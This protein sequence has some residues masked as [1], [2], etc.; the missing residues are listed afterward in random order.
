MEPNFVFFAY[1][2]FRLIQNL[3]K[4]IFSHAALDP[5]ALAA[6]A[7]IE[8]HVMTFFRLSIFQKN[9]KPI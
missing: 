3:L 4:L 2:T 6:Y 8:S 7:W 9:E 1:F 5:Q